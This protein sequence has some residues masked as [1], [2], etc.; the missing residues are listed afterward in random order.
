[1]EKRRHAMLRKVIK[2]V[3]LVILITFLLSSCAESTPEVKEMIVTQIVE[4][5][6]VVT[7][8]VEVAGEEKVVEVTRVV[9]EEVEKV[10]TATPEPAPEKGLGPR[11]DNTLIVGTAQEP[12]RMCGAFLQISAAGEVVEGPILRHMIE[13]DGEGNWV[14]ILVEEIPTVENGLWQV[15]D[16][17]S[18]TIT[19]NFKKGLLWSD[20]EEI[21]AEDVLFTFNLSKDENVPFPYLN[22]ER[23]V[24]TMSAPDPYT[25]VATYDSYDPFAWTGMFNILAEHNISPIYEE[26]KARAGNYGEAFVNDERVSQF[27]VQ[28]GPFVV[29]ER[30][31]GDRIVLEP[32]PYYN[33]GPAPQL[34][35]IIWK[36]IPDTQTL[37]ANVASLAV[38]ATGEIGLD[39]NS[40]RALANTE[41]LQGVVEI[42]TEGKAG[43]EHLVEKLDW[44][45]LADLRVRQAIMHAIDRQGIVDD[46]FQGLLTVAQSW[47]PPEHYAYTPVFEQYDYDPEMAIQLLEEAGWTLG[48]DGVRVNDQGERLSLEIMTNTGN[49]TREQIEEILQAQFAEVGIELVINNTPAG[50][51]FSEYVPKHLPYGFNYWGYWFYPTMLLQEFDWGGIMQGGNEW[52]GYR[53]P[54]MHDLLAQI[55]NATDQETRAALLIEAQQIIGD[56]VAIIPLYYSAKIYTVRSDFSGF[57]PTL[58]GLGGI[59]WNAEYWHWEQ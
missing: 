31:P 3:G 44:D 58:Y 17:G 50:V 38:D 13:E 27:C 8:L 41:A 18:M 49:T 39:F 54:E 11:G 24:A 43:L 23:K 22:E 21:T 45:V 29:V 57:E 1:M 47:L 7:Q 19:W 42:H 56:D 32:N 12:D 25:L 5:E 26:Y 35:R 36:V 46:L 53:N 28:N 51:M 4:K 37:A 40:A 34:D 16:D 6:V 30:I 10:V 55:R 48:P 15:N 9:Q 33:L 2:L 20:G 14:P 59:G 52:Y